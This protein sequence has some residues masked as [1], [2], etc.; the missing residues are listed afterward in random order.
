MYWLQRLHSRPAFHCLV[1]KTGIRHLVNLF[2]FVIPISRRLPSGIRYRIRYFESVLLAELI[3]RRRMYRFGVDYGSIRTFADLG[4]NVG[5]FPLFV[6]DEGRS[7]SLQGVAVEANEQLMHEIQW[8]LRVNGL[9]G[10]KPVV[11]LAGAAPHKDLTDFYTYTTNVAS[12][13]FAV[14]DPDHPGL[15]RWKKV[16]VPAVRMSSFWKSA[17]GDVRCNLLKL[18]IEGSEVTFILT[19]TE[20]LKRVDNII[21]EWHDYVVPHEPAHHEL[22]RLGFNLICHEQETEH[23]GTSYYSRGRLAST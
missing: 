4:A 12:S 18:D 11:G 7:T 23:F 17:L 21:V 2:L 8:H 14:D 13:A 6:A 9:T 3:F 16:T 19:E 20:F 22:I 5:F 15:G 10:V 1:K